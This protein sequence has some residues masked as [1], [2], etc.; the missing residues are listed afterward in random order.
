MVLRTVE[1]PDEEDRVPRYREVMMKLQPH[2]YH[3]LRR[4]YIHFARCLC[5]HYATTRH[6]C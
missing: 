1:I 3:F 5:P 4:V 2:N 6:D